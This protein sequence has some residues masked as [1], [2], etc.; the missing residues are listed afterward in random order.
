MRALALLTLAMIGPMAIAQVDEVTQG[1]VGVAFPVGQSDARMEAGWSVSF[2][3]IFWL[4]ER[5]GIQSELGVNR[6]G[7]SDRLRQDIGPATE[8]RVTVVAVPVNAFI[9]LH[10]PGTSGFYL[11]G[12]L[13]IY[14]R[15][16]E[17]S[18]PATLPVVYGD[19]WAGVA[20]GAKPS[21]TLTATRGGLDAG[22][23]WETPLEL[24]NLFVEIRYHRMFTRGRPTEFIP[25]LLGTRF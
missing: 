13:G 5:V 6:F 17:L 4:S 16:L 11:L 7:M 2:G 24:G 15:Q 18:D 14:H 9:R 25:V 10:Q 12:G 22:L 8:G 21:D 19:V 1:A 23:G 20:P 3:G